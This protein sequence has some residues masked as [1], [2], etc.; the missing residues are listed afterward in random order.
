MGDPGEL[1][2]TDAPPPRRTG[3]VMRADNRHILDTETFFIRKSRNLPTKICQILADKLCRSEIEPTR[4]PLP[5]RRPTTRPHLDASNTHQRGVWGGQ[6]CGGQGPILT[7]LRFS[8]HPH[9]WVLLSPPPLFRQNHES[10]SFRNHYTTS[11]RL[12]RYSVKGKVIAAL[13]RGRPAP[14]WP[15]KGL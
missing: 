8:P 6:R 11:L 12:H 7:A 1:D 9:R 14:H 13:Q 15:D 4:L 2:V 3:G 10:R 5:D